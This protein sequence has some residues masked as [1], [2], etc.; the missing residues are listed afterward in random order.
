MEERE[1]NRVLKVPKWLMQVL[2]HNAHAFCIPK[3]SGV[4]IAILIVFGEAIL[5]WLYLN[6]FNNF[7]V[8]FALVGIFVGITI[9][10]ISAFGV[11]VVRKDC[12]NCQFAFHILAHEK[13]HLRLDSRDEMYSQATSDYIQEKQ[14]RE[15]DSE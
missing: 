11:I 8:V 9:L 14:E 2:R 4:M 3:K 13:S 15:S 10:Y 1:H 12:Y 5:I 6:F 7:F